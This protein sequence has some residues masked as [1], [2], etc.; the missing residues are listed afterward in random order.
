M[1]PLQEK[2]SLSCLKLFSFHAVLSQTMEKA[3][4]W[5]D[6]MLTRY[7]VGCIS[8][9]GPQRKH[10]LGPIVEIDK[11]S[12]SQSGFLFILLTCTSKLKTSIWL[13]ALFYFL[14]AKW[15]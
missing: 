7:R 12:R 10:T 2:L 1:E 4:I 3:K 9:K 11:K 5:K 13:V 8:S 14:S 6:G 15:A